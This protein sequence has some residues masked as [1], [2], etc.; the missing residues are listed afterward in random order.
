MLLG[1]PDAVRAMAASAPTGVDAD[2]AIAAGTAGE[3][4]A[5]TT[6]AYRS[7]VMPLEGTPSV[8]RTLDAARASLSAPLV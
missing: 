7:S 6:A 5:P 8:M 3:R 2:T 1:E 4:S